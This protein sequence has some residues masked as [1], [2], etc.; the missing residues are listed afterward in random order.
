[1]TAKTVEER[2]RLFLLGLS[3]AMCLGT[4]VELWLAEHTE[5]L[6]Q[7]LPFILCGLGLAAVIAVLLRPG[8]STIWALRF[9]MG[10]AAFGSLVGVY[11][12]VASNLEVVREVNPNLAWAD[13]LWTATHGA[14]PLLAPGILV[15]AA[16]MAIAATYYHPALGNRDA[17]TRSKMVSDTN[18]GASVS[19]QQSADGQT[20]FGGER[21][22]QSTLYECGSPAV[23]RSG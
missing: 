6:L 7:L 3:G 15:L 22:S 23:S 19:T 20:G 21:D 11:E 10:L 18:L 12:H 4:I 2:L 17:V 13:A 16:L 8:R 14:A 5:Q 1:M 9:V